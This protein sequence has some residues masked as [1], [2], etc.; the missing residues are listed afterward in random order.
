LAPF[1]EANIGKG[2]E[3]GGGGGGGIFV[4]EEVNDNI[5]PFG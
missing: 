5:D 3:G 2:P 1:V 4:F